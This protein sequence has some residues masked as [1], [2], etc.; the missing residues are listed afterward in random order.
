MYSAVRP[1]EGD[2]SSYM[3]FDGLLE[4]ALELTTEILLR[5]EELPEQ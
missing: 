3:L 5:T 1:Y 2:S 4:E